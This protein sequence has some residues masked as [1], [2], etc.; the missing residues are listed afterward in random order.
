MSLPPTEP[1]EAKR[2]RH[3]RSTRTVRTVPEAAQATLPVSVSTV[4]YVSS[5]TAAMIDEVFGTTITST[6][7][8]A[9]AAATTVATVLSKL[10]DGV[11]ESDTPPPAPELE[12]ER[13]LFTE[14]YAEPGSRLRAQLIESDVVSPLEQMAQ[15]ANLPLDAAVERIARRLQTP[16]QVPTADF[17]VVRGLSD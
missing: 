7:S 2:R 4:Q 3:T 5:S 13:A 17:Y 10:K 14:T 6:A 12:N 8:P 11:Q 16:S 1:P 15:T 9:A